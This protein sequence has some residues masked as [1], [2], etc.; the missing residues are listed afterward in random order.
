MIHLNVYGDLVRPVGLR[1]WTTAGYETWRDHQNFTNQWTYQKSRCR[2]LTAIRKL[3]E[4]LTR[5]ENRNSVWII[6]AIFGSRFWLTYLQSGD[7]GHACFFIMKLWPLSCEKF[8]VLNAKIARKVILT[9]FYHHLDKKNPNKILGHFR[10]V[11]FFR[12]MSFF[13]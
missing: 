3:S 4:T 5:W 1:L 7:S 11:I 8:K 12:M 13:N 2:N 10:Q 9:D 6:L